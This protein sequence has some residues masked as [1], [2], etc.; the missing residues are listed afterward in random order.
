MEKFSLLDVSHICGLLLKAVGSAVLHLTAVNF[1]FIHQLF[2]EH[3]LCMFQAGLGTP[4]TT[5]AK[6][7][8]PSNTFLL[9]KCNQ[10]PRPEEVMPF[11]KSF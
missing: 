6:N 10:L 2:I 5:Y 1:S 8:F 3:L 7:H 11:R 4:V 9:G